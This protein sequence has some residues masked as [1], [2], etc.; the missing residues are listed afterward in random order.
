MHAVLDLRTSAVIPTLLCAVQSTIR[1]REP[2]WT[3]ATCER[4]GVVAAG[5]GASMGA[6]VAGVR[7]PPGAA[8]CAHGCRIERN[9]RVS[10]SASRLGMPS[11]LYAQRPI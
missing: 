7:V 2:A 6:E 11:I 4:V 5:G 10:S 9:A 8:G 3:P 1:W